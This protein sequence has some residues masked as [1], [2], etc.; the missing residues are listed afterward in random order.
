MSYEGPDQAVA[1]KAAGNPCLSDDAIGQCTAT[2][3]AQRLGYD[4]SQPVTSVAA[5]DGPVGC[6]G[7]CMSGPF[8]F[9]AGSGT[10]CQSQVPF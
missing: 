4:I 1:I 5:S 9:A 8:A 6:V 3:L 2:E 7:Y 10:H